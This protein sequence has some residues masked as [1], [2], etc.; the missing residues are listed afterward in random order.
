MKPENQQKLVARLR[1]LAGQ[2]RTL[3]V[4][5]AR[6]D[7]EKFIGQLEATIAA[8]KASLR[9]YLEQELLSKDELSARERKLL[10]RLI[11]KSA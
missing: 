8:A 1:R 10:A 7:P 11:E 5:L 4:T 6:R 2:A 9:F 3:E